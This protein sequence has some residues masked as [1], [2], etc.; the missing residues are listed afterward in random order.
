MKKEFPGYFANRNATNEELWDNCIFVLDANVL[1]NLYRYSD[2]TST[3]LLQVLSSLAG[4]LW[5]PHQVTLEYLSNRLTVIGDQLK[6]YDDASKAIG[7][8]KQSL[9]SQNQAPFVS[10]GLLAETV[11]LFAKLDAELMGNKQRH[12]LRITDDEIKNKLEVLLE[13]KVGVGYSKEQLELIIENGKSRY[14][15]KIPPGYQDIKKGG[16]SPLFSERC[17]P[18]GDY[19]VWLQILDKAKE[20]S[21]SVLFITGD[22]K[23]D[24]W[25]KFRGKTIGP[26]PQLTQEFQDTVGDLFYMYTPDRFLES[27]NKYLKREVSQKAVDEI[28]EVRVEEPSENFESQDARPS[29]YKYYQRARVKPDSSKSERTSDGRWSKRQEFTPSM[30]ES[31]ELP[32]NSEVQEHYDILL[33]QFEHLSATLSELE[34]KLVRE[35]EARHGMQVRI[36]ELISEGEMGSEESKYVQ[37]SLQTSAELI[38]TL[39][40]QA[41]EVRSELLMVNKMLGKTD[42]LR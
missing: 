7:A 14:D 25:E 5:V 15:E 8:L 13:G 9:E 16:D 31:M 1:L 24:W 19:I 39:K 32:W 28:R 26:R 4:R 38:M 17:K 35:R 40:S 37:L 23:D 6:V 18:Y 30:M 27:A 22:T 3:E 21:K 20:L 29:W 33:L 34:R 12:D 41:S 42:T 11:A 10:E 2:A 36:R